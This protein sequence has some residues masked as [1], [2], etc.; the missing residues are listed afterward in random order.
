MSRGVGKDHTANPGHCD[1]NL[2]PGS[3]GRDHINKS[4]GAREGAV[5]VG[6]TVVGRLDGDG[7]GGDDGAGVVGD[8]DGG[9]DGRNDGD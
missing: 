9:S 5:V 1:A 2:T 7:D 3:S 4:V 8:G 6:A